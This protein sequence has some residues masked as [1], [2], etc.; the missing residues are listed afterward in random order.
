LRTFSAITSRRPFTFL[1]VLLALLVIVAF[2]LVAL[3]AGQANSS[4]EQTVV[5]A[6]KDLQPRIPISTSDLATRT[7]FVPGN[8][9]KVY[10]GSVAEVTGMVPLVT[11]VNG[12]V[13][14]ANDVT[15]ADQAAGAQ[16][17]Y[18]PI[19][20]GYVA[21]T[22]PTSEEQGVGNRI[23]PGDY[24]SVIATVITNGRPATMTIFKQVHVIEVGAAAA[25]SAQSPT[26]LTVVV[27]ECQAEVITWFTH[28]AAL[29]YTLGSYK[30]YAPGD[31]N[32]DPKCPVD[33]ARGVT[34][35]FIQTAYPTLF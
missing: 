5:V 24:I 26:S 23:Q 1:G 9:P 30:D 13:V 34:L 16:S 3:N 14:S 7:I 4:P 28:Y 32:P 35:P 20:Q 27:T 2:V 8:Y 33:D 25:G 29:T 22:I 6:V 19:P 21:L 12:E 18:L 11:I 17:E 31:Q 15:R 10:F